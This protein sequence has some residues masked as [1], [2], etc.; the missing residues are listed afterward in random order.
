MKNTLVINKT[1]IKT[2][3][4]ITFLAVISAVA[5]P[6]VFHYIGVWS[7]SGAL[8]GTVF[9]PMHIPVFIAAFMAGPVV[10]AV[11]GVLSP[12]MSFVFTAS[13]L[14][15]AMPGSALLP[16]MALE[17]AG[18]GLTAGLLHKNNKLPV[19]VKLII[20][21]LAGRILR[22]TA[23]LISLYVIGLHNPVATV[24]SI[25]DSVIIGLPGILLQWALIPLLVYR[26]KGNK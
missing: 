5:L 19:F 6:Q 22:A 12:I 26:M 4:L 16:F 14:S 20:A 15:A 17:L 1:E 21:Q 23:I 10:G 7:G 11:A 9:L 25:W 24:S 18:F 8:A 2:K 3:T 13:V